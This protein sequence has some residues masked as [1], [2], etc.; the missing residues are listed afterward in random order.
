[1][2]NDTKAISFDYKP[3]GG[4]LPTQVGWGRL[5][6]Q[7]GLSYGEDDLLLETRSLSHDHR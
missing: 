3:R 5:T 4:E 6:V 7:M 2:V 1:M